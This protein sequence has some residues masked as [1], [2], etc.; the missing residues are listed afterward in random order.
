MTDIFDRLWMRYIE[1]NPKVEEIRNLF[2]AEGETVINDHIAL[3][4]FDDP[5]VNIEVLA[6]VFKKMGYVEKKSYHFSDKKLKA[7]HYEHKDAQR[8][9]VFISELE[10]SFFSK[11][12]QSIVENCLKSV[13]S[14]LTSHDDFV[15]SGRPWNHISFENYEILRSESEYAAWM[16]A[17]GYMA[18]HFTIKVNHLKKYPSISTVNSFLESKGVVLNSSGGKIKGTPKVFLE[19]SSTMANKQF[20]NFTEGKREIPSCYYEFAFRHKLENGNEFPDFIADNADKIFE[21]T[22]MH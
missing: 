1:V 17:W 8:P 2:I 3:R 6:Q 12:L 5:R 22:H 16:Y 20:V 10:L 11:E 13:T 14:I 18:N 21:S 7:K 15:N 4:T 19:Q 9:K